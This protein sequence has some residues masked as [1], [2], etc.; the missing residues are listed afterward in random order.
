IAEEARQAYCLAYAFCSL[1]FLLLVKGDFEEAVPALEKAQRICDE[2]EIKVLLTHVGAHLGYT[3]ALLERSEE[4]LRLLEHSDEL[5]DI[6][7]RKAGQSLRVTWHG[8]ARFLTGQVEEA[9]KYAAR[10]LALATQTKERGYEAWAHKLLGDI[11]ASDQEAEPDRSVQYY[12]KSLS[13]A[14]ELGMRPLQAHCCHGLGR[15][16]ARLNDVAKAG[17]ELLAAAEL[18]RVMS[19]PFWLSKAE[20]ALGELG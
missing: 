5:S 1:G 17:S 2:S 12:E 14:R 20:A 19:M 18:Y 8:H 4:G 16:H 3:Y 11:A 15:V 9:R 6:I 13:L 7:G 10:A